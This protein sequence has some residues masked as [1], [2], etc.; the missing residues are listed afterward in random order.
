[1]AWHR[2]GLELP[3]PG[4][5]VSG[6]DHKCWMRLGGSA[7]APELPTVWGMGDVFSVRLAGG[8][9]LCCLQILW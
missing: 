7:R 2:E 6:E 3:V 4:S 1:M 8:A 9:N 5:Q